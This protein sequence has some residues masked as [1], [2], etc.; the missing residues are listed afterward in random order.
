MNGPTNGN[1]T[2]T[3]CSR[4]KSGAGLRLC[5]RKPDTQLHV[6]PDADQDKPSQ[7]PSRK[8]VVLTSKLWG[9]RKHRLR[10]DRQIA[11]A[12]INVARR[13]RAVCSR[14]SRGHCRAASLRRVSM[15]L[16]AWPILPI[17]QWTLSCYSSEGFSKCHTFNHANAIVPF[18][19]LPKQEWIQ[20][21]NRVVDIFRVE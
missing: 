11:F 19:R 16:H 7:Q 12:V 1:Q 14:Q 2:R 15:I 18:P 10:S 17:A 3:I 20:L 5:K 13:L 8:S 21:L 9:G 6:S 4:S